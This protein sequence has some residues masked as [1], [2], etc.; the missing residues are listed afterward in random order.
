MLF[1][2][3]PA[4]TTMEKWLVIAFA[5]WEKLFTLEFEIHSLRIRNNKPGI[6]FT[7]QLKINRC[8]LN[9]IRKVSGKNV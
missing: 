8:V 5:N 9:L 2:M 1:K 6:I 7:N 4:A 3:R